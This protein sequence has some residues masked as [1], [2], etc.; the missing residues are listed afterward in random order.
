M[1]FPWLSSGRIPLGKSGM[2]TYFSS[3]QNELNGWELT[4]G[5][6]FPELTE[7]PTVS[8][9]IAALEGLNPGHANPFM[10]L[11]P[12]PLAGDAEANYFQALAEPDGYLC[13]ARVHEGADY[14]HSRAF[15]PDEEGGVGEDDEASLPNLTQAIR[16]ITTFM[17]NPCELP[18][19]EDVVWVDVTEQVDQHVSALDDA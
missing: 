14:C 18:E 8:Q 17:A 1:R 6:A 16:M 12:P 9:V 3:M 10:I 19:L 13:E 5:D 4:Q 2:I 11:V 15:L 7:N